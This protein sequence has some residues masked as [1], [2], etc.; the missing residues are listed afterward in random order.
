VSVPVV[1]T[2]C[3]LVRVGGANANDQGTG[4][5]SFGCVADDCPW[6]LNG[7]G[8]VATA[9]LLELLAAWGPQPGGHPA[10]F[11]GDM[12]VATADLL[13]LLAQWGA[14]EPV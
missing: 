3:Y 8:F 14:C 7:D 6:D 10:D 12:Q 11:N 1:E 9:D 13:K 5:I 4:Q 2:G